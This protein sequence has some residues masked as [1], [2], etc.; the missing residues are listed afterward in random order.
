[1]KNYVKLFSLFII[2]ALC[3]STLLAQVRTWDQVTKSKRQPVK[4]QS[5]QP[6]TMLEANQLK[7]PNQT[8]HEIYKLREAYRTQQGLSRDNYE[9]VISEGA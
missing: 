2:L 5:V 3:G 6:G 4:E 8:R 7:W 1:M 9:I